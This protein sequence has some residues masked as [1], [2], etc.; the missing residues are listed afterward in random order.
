M[1]EKIKDREVEKVIT[2]LQ[3]SSK[4]EIGYYNQDQAFYDIR[5]DKIVMPNA[6]F[7]VSDRGHVS[8]LIHEMAHSTGHQTRLNRNIDTAFFGTP[9]YA[10][11]ELRA[12]ISSIFLQND[13]RI[14]TDE[15]HFNNNNEYIKSWITILKN[16]PNEIYRASAEAEKISDFLLKEYRELEKVI[17]HEEINIKNSQKIEIIQPKFLAQN[18]VEKELAY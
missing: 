7:F 12:E 16:D 9:E 11:E 4:C 6:E 15:R 10:R 17:E 8:T 18:E 1:P 14:V 2:I 5:Q 13:L 3:K